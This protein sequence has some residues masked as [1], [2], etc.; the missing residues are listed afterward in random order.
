SGDIN[1]NQPI[2]QWNEVDSAISYQ[3][4]VTDTD[5]AEMVIDQE[6]ALTECNEGV[7]ATTP[8]VTLN[9]F[10]Y[11]FEVAANYGSVQ[12]GFSDPMTFRVDG[13]PPTNPTN[14]TSSSHTVNVWSADTMVDVSWSGATDGSGSGI[15]GYSVEWSNSSTMV[16]DAIVD[17]VE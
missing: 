17:T 8:A 2:Y 5:T 1:S 15:S 7:C 3:L 13:T 9:A 14:I 16:P 10:N 11:Q 4:Q 6:V 12:G